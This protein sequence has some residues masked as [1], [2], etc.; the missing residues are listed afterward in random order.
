MFLLGMAGGRSVAAPAGRFAGTSRHLLVGGCLVAFAGFLMFWL[1]HV[2]YVA[3]AGLG[4]A[5]VGVALL[6][7][8]AVTRAI[9]ACPGEQDR[10]AARCALASGLAIG[11]APLILAQLADTT[12]LRAAY[13][14]VPG[15][16]AALFV[17]AWC[18]R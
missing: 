18:A 16:L 11:G 6:Y 14:I 17:H 13:L 1:A 3:G 12:G 7:P 8:A 9:T 5:G 10:A 2:S 4:V 15:L